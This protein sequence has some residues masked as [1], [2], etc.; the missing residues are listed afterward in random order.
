MKKMRKM[1]DAASTPWRDMTTEYK[2]R[3]QIIEKETVN[4]R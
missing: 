2:E 4:W 3:E 1:R